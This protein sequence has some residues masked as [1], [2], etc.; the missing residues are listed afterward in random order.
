MQRNTVQR[1]GYN[2]WEPRSGSKMDKGMIGHVPTD[3][4]TYG[5]SF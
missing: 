2:K 5:A 4:T 3:W 1:V